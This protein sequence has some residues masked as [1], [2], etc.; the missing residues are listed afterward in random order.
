MRYGYIYKITI[1]VS[2]K[3]MSYIG[4][5]KSNTVCENYFGSGRKINDWFKKHTGYK[6]RC[7][8]ASEAIKV[9]VKR[10]ILCWCNDAQTLSNR[11]IEFI[12]KQR[13]IGDCLNIADG[14][15]NG[16]SKESHAKSVGT[17]KKN[18]SYKH[19]EE[20]KL[21]I[22]L[23][24]KGKKLNISPKGH[25]K[26]SEKMKGSNN[27]MSKEKGGHTK[28]WRELHSKQMKGRKH[29]YCAKKVICL[30]TKQI[31]RSVNDAG[32]WAGCAGVL[33]S[34][35]CKKAV[36]KGYQCKTAKGYHFSFL[37]DYNE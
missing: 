33:I 10:E 25:Q 37:E 9:G 1:P 28:E 27:P 6:S 34:M 12:N 8:P 23:R 2:G 17:R 3:N 29:D 26:L 30:E 20:Q 24:M 14:G 4:Q 19:T 11:E 35:V 21:A 32:N 36:I 31:F 7:C 16:W 5:K 22:S 15:E 18:G 13:E